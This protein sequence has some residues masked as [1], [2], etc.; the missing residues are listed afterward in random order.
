[1]S[2]WKYFCEYRRPAHL[3]TK[4]TKKNHKH[5]K[6]S[7]QTSTKV[8]ILVSEA[9]LHRR[10]PVEKTWF[11]KNI[12]RSS[13]GTSVFPWQDQLKKKANVVKLRFLRISCKRK[14]LEHV[15]KIKISKRWKVSA[16]RSGAVTISVEKVVSGRLNS[17]AK[18]CFT[19]LNISFSG[20]VSVSSWQEFA[21]IFI[22]WKKDTV[23]LGC[24]SFAS[25]GGFSILPKQPILGNFELGFRIW[26]KSKN[27]TDRGGGHVN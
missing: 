15:L 2:I 10:I 1:M 7:A 8:A 25:T 13:R 26:S 9:V 16:Q 14:L 24:E 23:F 12:F 19:K 27:L 6:V 21:K 18:L 11:S 5:W 20:M 17:V 22:F 3:K 4:N